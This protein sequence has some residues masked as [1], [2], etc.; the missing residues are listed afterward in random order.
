MQTAW[1]VGAELDGLLDIRR[2]RGAGYKVDR[3]RHRPE[4]GAQPCPHVLD[5]GNES[6]GAQHDDVHIGQKVER[7]RVLAARDQH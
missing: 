2:A 6:I 5:V 1:P 7:G 3:A 4:L